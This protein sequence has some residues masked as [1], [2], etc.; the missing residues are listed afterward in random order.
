MFEWAEWQGLPHEQGRTI[1]INMVM[2]VGYLFACRSLRLPL[3]R[4]GLF[5]NVWV[6]AAAAMLSTQLLFTY[7]LVMNRF[8]HTAPIDAWWWS[9]MTCLGGAVLVLSELKKI[10]SSLLAARS[11]R[12]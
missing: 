4:T 3:W 12:A 9:V 1:A 6:W 5:S 11:R 2:E 10:L 8:F 7:L